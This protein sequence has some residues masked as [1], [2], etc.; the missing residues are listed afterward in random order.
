[1]T[2]VGLGVVT[3]NRPHFF[4]R[5]AEAINKSGVA[6]VVDVLVVSND[7]SDPAHA[8][9]YGEAYRSLRPFQA[10]FLATRSNQ[11][12]AHAKNHAM[13]YLLDNDCDWI[14]I[15]EDDVMPR[16]HEAVTG[17]LK[18]AQNGPWSHLCF[19]AHGDRNSAPL[20]ESTRCHDL[21]EHHR[22]LVYLLGS[23]PARRR[24]HGRGDGQRLRAR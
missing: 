1:M 6:D 11:G 4:A 15:G 19:H 8:H 20:Y 7:G 13:Q 10:V 2:R 18:A 14:I 21:A 22:H 12:V 5:T 23:V 16:T 24:T 9:S 3:Y 17:Y